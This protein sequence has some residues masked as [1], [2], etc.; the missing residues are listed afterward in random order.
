MGNLAIGVGQGA[1]IALA[2]V[3][4]TLLWK[5][6]GVVNLSLGAYFLGGGLL[7]WLFDSNFDLPLLSEEKRIKEVGQNSKKK[8]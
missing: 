4:F 2:T 5:V 3:G 8:K 7:S 1:A 6:S